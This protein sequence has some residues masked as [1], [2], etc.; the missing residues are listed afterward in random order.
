MGKDGY[1]YTAIGDL[2]NEGNLQNVADGPSP[3]DSSVILRINPKDGSAPIVNPFAEVSKSYPESQMDKYYGYGIRN[4]FGLAIDP[5]TG[6]LWETENGD[7]DYDEINL[8]MP[9]F[10]GGWK[11]LMGPISKSK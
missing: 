11:E 5:L 10:N 4:S 7:R 6:F 9:G 1:L 8:V 2:N 3:S